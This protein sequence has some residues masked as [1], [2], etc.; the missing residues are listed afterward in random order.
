MICGEEKGNV[1]TLRVN[2]ADRARASTSKPA[3]ERRAEGIRE[4]S[5]AADHV[6][7]VSQDRSGGAPPTGT[8]EG[9]RPEKENP[10]LQCKSSQHQITVLSAGSQ[11]WGKTIRRAGRRQALGTG[12]PSAAGLQG[13][14]RCD[15]PTPGLL[16]HE[17]GAEKA[18]WPANSRPLYLPP[19]RGES[20]RV[21][22]RNQDRVSRKPPSCS[23][24]SARSSSTTWWVQG[25]ALRRGKARREV[26]HVSIATLG[27]SSVSSTRQVAACGVCGR[28]QP[29]ACGTSA[30]G[31]R[32]EREGCYA[33]GDSLLRLDGK[34]AAV[35]GGG[36]GGG[37][38][39]G[40]GHGRRAAGEGAGGAAAAAEGAAGGR[41][42]GEG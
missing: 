3:A 29:A 39:A 23:A 17:Q 8:R 21:M 27:A 41:A 4:R 25:K 16:C 38:A 20:L 15:E 2:T 14:S 40:E 36:G 31:R 1:G 7:R 26:W 12:S 6:P 33:K 18:A 22:A 32:H 30:A 19:A 13:L 28:R 9:G 5:T 11:N 37:G 35:V 42:G 10:P 34:L 24:C